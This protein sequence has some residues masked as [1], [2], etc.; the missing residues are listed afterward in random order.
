MAEETIRIGYI[1]LP[2]GTAQP[3]CEP[4]VDPFLLELW[5][6]AG[7]AIITGDHY[8]AIV[9]LEQPVVIEGRL[10]PNELVSMIGQM[11]H[12]AVVHMAAAMKNITEQYPFQMVAECVVAQADSRLFASLDQPFVETEPP[13]VI[14]KTEKSRSLSLEPPKIMY[15]GSRVRVIV[16]GHEDTHPLR[17]WADRVICQRVHDAIL[18]EIAASAENEA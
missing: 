2:D 16:T 10:S 15:D 6:N 12:E 14:A 4:P 3:V 9:S 1:R 13:R 17:R 8:L 7:R 5:N 18:V 11:A